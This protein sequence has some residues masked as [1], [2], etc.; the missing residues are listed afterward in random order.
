MIGSLL[1]IAYIGGNMETKN[2]KIIDEHGIDRNGNVICTLG[3]DGKE[4]VL[5]SIERDLDNDNLFISLLTKNNDGTSNMV[6]IEDS[7]EKNAISD[8]AK[9]VITFSVNNEA[10]KTTGNVKLANG[11]EVT[12]GTALFNKEQ[13]INVTKTYI[14]TVKKSVTK[15][16]EDFYKVENVQPSAPLNIFES[17]VE[18]PE[19]PIESVGSVVEK[20][21]ESVEPI[22]STANPEVVN[23]V[24]SETPK[25]INPMTPEVNGPTVEP[26]LPVEPIASE[27]VVPET[28]IS[29]VTPTVEPILPTVNPE[30]ATVQESPSVPEPILPVN[31]P[32]IP[33]TSTTNDNPGLVIDGSKETNLNAALGE[34]TSDATLPVQDVSPI[35]EF[36]QDQVLPSAN[37]ANVP[38]T[39]NLEPTAPVPPVANS[40]FANNKFFTVIAI[41]LFVGA[42]VFLGYEA[43]RY[44]SIVK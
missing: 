34:M 17:A 11:K 6:N 38:P 2:V 40:G 22:L 1:P 24:V 36:G 32:V 3:V 35:R 26:I 10:D 23:P 18:T 43:F 13:S 37:V 15:V 30:T 39:V 5:Y 19:I 21:P 41:L 27:P 4:Y 20:V 42:C 25:V 14:T 12:I 16:S 8:I 9:Q 28:P 31:E 33:A 29:V 44:F 7:M